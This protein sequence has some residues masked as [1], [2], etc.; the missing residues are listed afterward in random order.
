MWANIQLRSLIRSRPTL[1]YEQAHILYKY[2]I[3]AIFMIIPVDLW[4]LSVHSYS[5]IKH[6]VPATAFLS[7]LRINCGEAYPVLSPT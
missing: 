2:R 3:Y 6:D 4:V 1:D 7:V 5:G